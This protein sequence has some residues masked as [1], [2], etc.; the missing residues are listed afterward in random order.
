V[1]I[2]SLEVPAPEAEPLKRARKWPVA[3]SA[4][5]ITVGLFIL[6]WLIAPGALAPSALGPLFAYAGI[7]AV[8]AIGQTIVIMLRG[9]D[10]S[11]PGMMTV[12]AVVLAKFAN[13]NGDNFVFALIVVLVIAVLVGL[14][15]GLCVTRLNVSPLVVTLAMNAALVGGAIA[16]TGGELM[17]APEVIT[18]FSASTTLG[19]PNTVWLALGLVIV[20]G[21]ATSRTAWG[22]KLAAVGSNERSARAAGIS[23]EGVKISGYIV[24]AV[25]FAIAGVALAG[26]VQSPNI[27]VGTPFL[28]PCIA[29]VVVGGTTLAGGKGTVVGTAIG[30]VFL[31]LLSH[32]VL[33]LGA[34]P[35]TQR[36]LEAVVIAAAVLTQRLNVKSLWGQMSKRSGPANLP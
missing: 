6:T 1:N 10:L 20:G 9:I 12:G 2:K 29:A 36:I 15:N 22:R 23:V 8:A 17:R 11:V 24:A 25:T 13:D 21:V 16:Y 34:P 32:L 3:G 30:A 18:D 28:L 27:E 4:A 31:T 7:L 5:I 26:Y 14:A 19:L 33:S 35:S